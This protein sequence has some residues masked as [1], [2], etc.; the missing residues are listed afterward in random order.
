MKIIRTLKEDDLDQVAVLFANVYRGPSSSLQAIQSYFREVLFQNP[1]FDVDLP[2][3]VYEDDG[4]IVGVMAI[5]P[6]RM[7]LEGCP[8]RMAV[9][10]S[11]FID[12]QHRNRLAGLHLLQKFMAGP[13]DVSLI[14]GPSEVVAGIWQRLG[15]EA[16]PFH[17]LRWLRPLRPAR[18]V[19]DS[20]SRSHLGQ[21][22]PSG[23]GFYFGGLLCD[24]LDV[25][26]TRLVPRPERPPADLQAERLDAPVL[27]SSLSKFA[28][29]YRFRPEYSLRELEWLLDQLEKK[30]MHGALQR[31]LIRC[32][33]R[34]IV[35]WYLYYLNS[36]GVCEVL[37]IGAR[38]DSTGEVLNHLFD[39]ARSRGAAA[40][41]GWVEPKL[42][43]ALCDRYCIFHGR[44]SKFL[45][46]ARNL[47]AREAMLA[48]DGLLTRMEGEW[49]L[50]FTESLDKN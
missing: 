15:G 12:P 36:T 11:L 14:S 42:V 46:H 35:G 1:W 5:I 48:G 10:C 25:A 26:L 18:T 16:L 37:R 45:F 21:P 40:L 34:G 20:Y 31:V 8:V 47:D 6:R 38:E 29:S 49:W 4:K 30:K 13:Q 27:L 2:S 23:L 7:S 24:C 43:H 28:A 17:N 33:R 32:K 50:R 19:L 44:A 39:H 3:W 41:H 22:G 9:G